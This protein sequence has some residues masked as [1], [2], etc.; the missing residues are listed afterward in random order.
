[1]SDQ[2]TSGITSYVREAVAAVE[3]GAAYI[4]HDLLAAESTIQTWEAANPTVAPFLKTGVI[5]AE[6]MLTRFGLPVGAVSIVGE[7]IV[8]ALKQMAAT[9]ASVPSQ[10]VT[11][12]SVKPPA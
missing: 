5:Y 3:K 8:A 1:M 6:G 10:P 2:S 7:D 4:Y 12:S 11:G 9:D